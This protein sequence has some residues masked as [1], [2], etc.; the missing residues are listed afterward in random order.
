MAQ[1]HI[2]QLRVGLG[3]EPADRECAEPQQ[4]TKLGRALFLSVEDKREGQDAGKHHQFPV[5]A[6]EQVVAVASSA[7]WDR[8][9]CHD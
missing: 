4:E 7:D 9:Q 8:S 5:A 2:A 1:I 3:H 6:H